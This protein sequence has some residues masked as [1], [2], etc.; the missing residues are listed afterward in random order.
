MKHLGS[1][2]IR[3]LLP[4]ALAAAPFTAPA[5]DVGAVIA[6]L[7]E[8]IRLLDERTRSLQAEI[9]QLK[10]ENRGLRDQAASG[11]YVTLAQFNSALAELERALR[12]GDREL[13]IQLTQQMER[14]AKQTQAAIDTVAKAA[15]ARAPAQTIQFTSDFPST[16]TTYVVQ[17]GD[18]L[19]SIAQRFGS[20]VRDIQN[21]NKIA[22]ATK[23]QAGQT[24]FIPQKQQ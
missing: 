20:S 18:T 5:Q 7:R 10:R 22:D 21:A 14:M 12:A 13:A 2:L 9:E 1:R 11:Q 4:A 17:P 15:G 16:G 8:D 24:L 19:S 6:G 3:W 23:L